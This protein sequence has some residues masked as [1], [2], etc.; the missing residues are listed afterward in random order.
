M[1]QTNAPDR[2]GIALAIGFAW[3]ARASRQRALHGD[4]HSV[5]AA[6][7]ARPGMHAEV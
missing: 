4:A 2:T 3:L 1:Q 7:S 6:S 5:W